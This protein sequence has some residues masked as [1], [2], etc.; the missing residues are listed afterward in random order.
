MRV[1]LRTQG[2]VPTEA[3][4]SL[5]ERRLA[6]AAGRFASRL[7]AVSVRLGDV[8]GPRG[9]DDKTCRV[10]ASVAGAGRVVVEDAD[11][12]LHAAIARAAARFGRAVARAVERRRA[13]GGRA[14]RAWRV[15]AR[16]PAF[17][18]E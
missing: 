14:A 11:A 13:P 2:L 16:P 15:L 3:I 12:D 10:A 4:S 5:V 18:V 1:T 9:G 6:F 8:N 17:G 7:A